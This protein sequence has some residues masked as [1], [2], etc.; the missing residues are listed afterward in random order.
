MEKILRATSCRMQSVRSYAASFV[1]VGLRV[2]SEIKRVAGLVQIRVPKGYRQARSVYTNGGCVVV[3]IALYPRPYWPYGM[4]R[5][6]TP[7]ERDKSSRSKLTSKLYTYICNS[8]PLYPAERS[9]SGYK[10]HRLFRRVIRVFDF[11][12]EHCFEYITGVLVQRGQ[13]EVGNNF[14]MKRAIL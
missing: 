2:R 13:S 6:P 7:S 5:Q 1:P 12:H 4:W 11:W 9:D 10:G 14:F 3:L 8:Y